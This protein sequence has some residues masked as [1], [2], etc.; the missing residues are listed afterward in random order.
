[1]RRCQI[2]TILERVISLGDSVVGLES[3]KVVNVKL[4][5][6]SSGGLTTGLTGLQTLQSSLLKVRLVNLQAS[7]LGHDL[8]E[9]DGETVSVVQSPNVFA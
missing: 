7:L 1:M 4:D 8:G 2:L 3:G 5:A 6:D 9:V